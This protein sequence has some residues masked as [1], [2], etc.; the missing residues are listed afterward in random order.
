[1]TSAVKN[2]P[3]AKRPGVVDLFSAQ[4]SSETI[5]KTHTTELVIA[6]C[7]PIGSPL[8]DVAAALETKLLNTFDY[9][10]CTKI[11]MSSLISDYADK[12]QKQIPAKAGFE[13]IQAQIN[14]GND[15]RAK[16]GASVL[17]ELA[18]NAIRLAREIEKGR[19]RRGFSCSQA[20]LS[21]H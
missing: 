6:L 5:A 20:G 17:A 3:K 13:K 21:H 9:Q 2:A 19:N 14:V 7:G 4:K 16:Y 1:M 18:V 10:K 15:L 11:R 8:H 12:V